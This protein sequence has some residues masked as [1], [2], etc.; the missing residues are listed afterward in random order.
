[1]AELSD[2]IVEANRR[3]AMDLLEVQAT[4]ERGFLKRTSDFLTGQS[5]AEERLPALGSI[6]E[7]LT[8]GQK[9]K[10]AGGMLSTPAEKARAEIIL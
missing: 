2:V 8:T 3:E 1:M 5:P 4:E 9:I 10:I 7:G 6:G